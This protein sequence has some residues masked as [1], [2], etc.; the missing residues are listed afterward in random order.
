VK[1]LGTSF[2]CVIIKF[3]DQE[4]MKIKLLA[5]KSSRYS[6]FSLIELVVVLAI[7]IILGAI[8][9]STYSGYLRKV[10]IAD[11]YNSME[12]IKKGQT[13]YYIE[14]KSFHWMGVNPWNQDTRSL[15]ADTDAITNQTS[16]NTLLN[17]IPV[18]KQ[19]SFVYMALD[20]KNDASGTGIWN[21]GS[22][23]EDST[24]NPMWVGDTGSSYNLNNQTGNCDQVWRSEFLPINSTPYYTWVYIEARANL[25]NQNASHDDCTTI[26]LTMDTDSHGKIRAHTVQTKNLGE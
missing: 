19:T 1:N 18:G 9:M 8:G 26:V 4:I 15:P 5:K 10:K 24:D 20:G 25:I 21:F 13:V 22:Q 17:P 23:A 14:H 7:V 3:F 6:A 16:W 11:V 2:F 12:L